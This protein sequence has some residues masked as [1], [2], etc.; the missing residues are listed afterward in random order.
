MCK[1]ERE[2]N[3]ENFNIH[4]KDFPTTKLTLYV[5]QTKFQTTQRKGNEARMNILRMLAVS[6]PCVSYHNKQY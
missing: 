2:R 4:A 1:R 6:I 3:N 5:L